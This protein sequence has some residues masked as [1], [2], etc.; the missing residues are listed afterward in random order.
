MGTPETESPGPDVS[1]GLSVRSFLLRPPQ[2]EL[3]MRRTVVP[4]LFR[5]PG[6]P[7]E[8]CRT[9]TPTFPPPL[10][11]HYWSRID[12]SRPKVKPSRDRWWVL[13]PFHERRSS[14]FRLRVD[15]MGTL[16]CFRSEYSLQAVTPWGVGQ[17]SSPVG[18]SPGIPDTGFW[19]P[20]HQRHR[21]TPLQVL[22]ESIPDIG[23]TSPDGREVNGHWDL[24]FES[25]PQDKVS[26]RWTQGSG[27]EAHPRLTG[28]RSVKLRDR[29]QG[30]RLFTLGLSCI[31]R[32]GVLSLPDPDL[33]THVLL[34]PHNHTGYNLFDQYL[35]RTFIQI[36]TYVCPSRSTECGH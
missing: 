36:F 1:S 3:P 8:L 10:P 20:R 17:G 30:V 24:R 25:P 18:T 12:V 35:S 32:V 31:S 7:G 21:P 11:P 16:L 5:V 15:D 34:L 33:S 29:S 27:T 26:V 19:V 4:G 23:S 22:S 6:Y 14:S 2:L 9:P 28:T 13:N